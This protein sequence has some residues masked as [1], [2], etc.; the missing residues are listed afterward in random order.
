MISR[1]KYMKIQC[2][3]TLIELMISL[4]L[5]LLLMSAV[6]AMYTGTLESNALVLDASRLNQETTTL[7]NVMVSEIRRSGYDDDFNVDDIFSNNFS[8][9]D[10]SEITIVSGASAF[11]LSQEL[12]GGAGLGSGN[13]ILFAYD[14]N[15]NG[16]FDVDEA[17]GFRLS[18]EAVQMR[19]GVSSITQANVQSCTSGTWV[20]ISDD[21]LIKIKSLGFDNSSS[22]C[23]YV[24]FSS[25]A[26]CFDSG[27]SSSET[28]GTGEAIVVK[29]NI[30]VTLLAELQR[31]ELVKTSA[32]HA[33]RVRNNLIFTP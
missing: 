24:N 22:V 11:R 16:S 9:P 10:L 5:G 17:K 32:T 21:S 20:D 18:G 15:K 1:S 19:T 8:D 2:G 25:E 14:A 7:M 3:V 28:V 33:V 29:Q 4:A 30:V 31:D 26:D 13:C 6:L 12:S 27:F 23:H